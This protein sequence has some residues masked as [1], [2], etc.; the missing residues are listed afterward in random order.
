MLA[1][2]E[3]DGLII[4]TDWNGDKFFKY[5]PYDLKKNSHLYH[6]YGIINHYEQFKDEHLSEERRIWYVAMTRARQLLYLSCPKP[7]AEDSRR[8]SS[9]D[10][11]L[12]VYEEF[13]NK[14]TI[15]EF[16]NPMTAEEYTEAE[17]PLWRSREEP[18]FRSIEEAEKYGERLMELI[19]SW[20]SAGKT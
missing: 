7:I 10:F 12:E 3:E 19:A 14:S 9:A 18:I 20:R 4:N 8:G 15:C 13:A 6:E 11:F 5:Q 17:L 2:H 16:R 1:L